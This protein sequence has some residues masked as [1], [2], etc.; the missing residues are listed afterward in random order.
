M[1]LVAHLN[2]LGGKLDAMPLLITDCVVTVVFCPELP[3]PGVLQADLSGVLRSPLLARLS[4]DV[5]ML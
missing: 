4:G 1:S 3:A 2:I 5:K